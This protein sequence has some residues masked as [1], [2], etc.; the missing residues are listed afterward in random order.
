MWTEGAAKK[1]IKDT[2]P[3][4]VVMS[5]WEGE[6]EKTPSWTSSLEAAAAQEPSPHHHPCRAL[7]NAYLT[8]ELQKKNIPGQHKT[9]LDFGYTLPPLLQPRMKPGTSP[10][11]QMQ[12]WECVEGCL[13]N[14]F[15][16][17][18]L[19]FSI[20]LSPLLYLSLNSFMVIYGLAHTLI[21][22][23]ANI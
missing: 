11:S 23:H 15:P 8:E 9:D 19:S 18:L 22:Q 16:A 10:A 7:S 6:W 12:F 14:P 17:L 2:G 21:P 4:V 3:I 13:Y 5:M 20:S 1:W